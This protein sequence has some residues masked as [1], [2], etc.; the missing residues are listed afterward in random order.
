MTPVK[1]TRRTRMAVGA[2]ALTAAAGA[3]AV[4]WS[5]SAS[6]DQQTVAG[7][8]R[9]DAAQLATVKSAFTA[10]IQADRAATAPPAGAM[11]PLLAGQIAPPAA[12]QVR[13]QQLAGGLAALAAHFTPAQ[14]Q[15]EAIG[16]RNAVSYE[17]DPA[18]RNLGAGASKVVFTQVAVAGSRA[19]VQAQVTVWARF[20]Q[21]RPNGSWT[22]ASPVNVMTYTAT[23]VKNAAGQWVVSSLSG[24]FAPGEGP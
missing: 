1:R 22:T 23:L 8:V 21:R 17:A 18:F 10:A 20:Q 2:L 7:A 11:H 12:P 6:G 16:L 3:A 5:D 9:S 19:T 24:D 14:A 13:Q 15:H 4:N